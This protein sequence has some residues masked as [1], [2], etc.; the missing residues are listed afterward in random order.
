[1]ENSSPFYPSINRGS[2]IESN[3]LN[4]VSINELGNQ[5]YIGG[6]KCNYTPI[7]ENSRYATE[8]YPCVWQ[9][10][11]GAGKWTNDYIYSG[12]SIGYYPYESNNS[13]TQI[14]FNQLAL[15]YNG[16]FKNFINKNG[17]ILSLTE[18]LT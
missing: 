11:T 10:T 5:V 4:L 9:F 7:L 1:M 2:Y 3:R 16:S 6:V 12:T 17:N 13:T 14:S 15:K 8:C 18:V